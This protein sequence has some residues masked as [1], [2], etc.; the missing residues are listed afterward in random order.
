[1][2]SIGLDVGQ[3]NDPAAVAVLHTTGPRPESHRP[4]WEALCVRNLPLGTPYRK[5][6]T[7]LVAVARDFT[8]AGYAVVATVDAT[9]IGA[10]VLEYARA[11]DPRLHIVGVTIGAGRALE[12]AGPDDYVVGK[13]RLTEVL[14][15]ALEQRG[16]TV[17]DADESRHLGAQLRAFTRK[18]TA[19]GYE[20]HEADHGHDD[21][22]LAL[23]LAI[24]T[25]DLMHDQHAGVAP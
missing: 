21:L 5:L 25:G 10:A 12:H 8:A 3:K 2:I 23:E 1:M 11:E 24:W 20:R 15:V 14:Q 19:S 9:G 7:H 16:L 6:A 18:P 13:H 4:H 22:V 17:V